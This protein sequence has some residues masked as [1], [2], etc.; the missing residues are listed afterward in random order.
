ML[1]YCS[2]PS[3]II[4]GK[5]NLNEEID[6]IEIVNITEKYYHL[7]Q[8]NIQGKRLTSRGEASQPA[9][10]AAA[11]GGADAWWLIGWITALPSRPGGRLGVDWSDRGLVE[12]VD[13]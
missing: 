3:Y 5:K 6:I 12:V 1:T 4:Q 13:F 10:A 8:R 11:G 2:V 9:A 7:I